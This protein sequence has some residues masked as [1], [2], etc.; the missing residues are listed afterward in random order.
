[1]RMAPPR[2]SW[3]AAMVRCGSRRLL[4]DRGVEVNAAN[5]Y[6]ATPLYTACAFNYP[7]IVR[8]LIDSGA[9]VD[10]EDEHG[11][12]RFGSRAPMAT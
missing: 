2:L 3:R 8:L 7:H 12:T 1:M 10:K 9:D 6:G 11:L 4:I 5:N